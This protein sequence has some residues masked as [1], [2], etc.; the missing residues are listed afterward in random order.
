[1][2]QARLR[3]P[4][5]LRQRL[6]DCS[7]KTSK[8]FVLQKAVLPPNLVGGRKWCMRIHVLEVAAKHPHQYPQ[9]AQC[10]MHEDF[11]ALEHAELYEAA[12][13]KKA[14]HVQQV[15]KGHPEPYS[16]HSRYRC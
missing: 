11:I 3:G 12:S 7:S 6:S 15:G 14:V 8:D 9:G 10:F 2:C 16:K 5:Q 13:N 1:M 4:K